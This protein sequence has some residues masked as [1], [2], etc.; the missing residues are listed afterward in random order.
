MSR[1]IDQFLKDRISNTVPRGRVLDFP[2]GDGRLSVLLDAEGYT[3]VPA[4]LFPESL[5]WEGHE[6]V[7]ADMNARFPFEDA[8]FD[9]IVSQEGVE[10]LENLASFFRECRRTLRPGGMLFLTTPNFMDLSS[11]FAYLL[12]GMKSF[13]AGFTNEE[14]T[15]W[16]RDDERFYH[17]HAFSL[18]FFQIRYLLR[19]SGFGEVRLKG[20]DRS[21]TSMA[22]FWP[23]RPVAGLMIG[24]AYRKLERKAR[25]RD[26]EKRVPSAELRQELSRWALSKELLCYKKICVWATAE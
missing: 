20:L 9:A 2:A 8:T 11:R 23:V 13:H 5:R 17:G 14:T 7:R 15:L 25:Q 21:G 3:A 19:V 22:L 6:S 16:G 26:R 10:H 12:T 24:R 1:R 18:P 4:D